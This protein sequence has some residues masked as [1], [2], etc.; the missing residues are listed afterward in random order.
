MT[1]E[2]QETRHAMKDR[3][4]DRQDMLVLALGWLAALWVTLS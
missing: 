3:P 4:I 2:A 1:H